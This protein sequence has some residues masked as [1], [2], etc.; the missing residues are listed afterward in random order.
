MPPH[1]RQSTGDRASQRQAPR[2]ADEALA[3]ALVLLLVFER[4]AR[5]LVETAGIHQHVVRPQ[6]HASIACPTREAHALVDQLSAEAETAVLRIDEQ[7]PQLRDLRR[8]A[9][10]EDGAG[11]LARGLGDDRRFGRRVVLAR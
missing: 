5:A 1:T 3:E 8:L 10:A 9:H 11:A 4:E 6:D 2:L 7:Q